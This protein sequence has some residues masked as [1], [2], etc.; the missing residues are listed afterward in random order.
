MCARSPMGVNSLLIALKPR[1]V[2]EIMDEAAVGDL[3][4]LTSPNVTDRAGRGSE[5]RMRGLA[6]VHTKHPKHCHQCLRAPSQETPL[7]VASP[8]Q[9]LGGGG[10]GQQDEG[11]KK[12]QKDD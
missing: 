5:N 3:N 8:P 10:R 1:A 2:G 12:T 9:G 4:P 6:T 7:S 11:M